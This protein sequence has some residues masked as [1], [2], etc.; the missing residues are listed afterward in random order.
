MSSTLALASQSPRRLAL[1]QGAGLRV[2]VVPSRA[3]P[4]LQP[5]LAGA[6]QALASARAKLPAKADGVV[7]SAD[8]VVHL[9][10]RCL[11]KPANR[12]EAKAML[13]LLSGQAHQVTSA[14][15]LR[16]G[17]EERWFSVTAEVLFRRLSEAEIDRY[18]ATDEPLDKAGAYGIQGLGAGLVE[19]VRGSHSAVVGLPLSQTLAALAHW[20]IFP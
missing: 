6:Q 9:S 14:V 5:R 20:G 12:H 11:G 18:V 7:L 13:M 3:E 16:R 1:L 19:E 17:E 10:E 15:A 2:V 8:T 4:P